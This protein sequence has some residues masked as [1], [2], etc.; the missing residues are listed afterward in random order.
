MGT[1]TK[2]GREFEFDDDTPADV[3]D[4]R[5]ANWMKEN[6]ANEL[7]PEAPKES[8]S[9]Y[10]PKLAMLAKMMGAALPGANLLLDSPAGKR[11]TGDVNAYRTIAQGALPLADEA[12]AGVRSM[13]PESWGGA[14]YDTALGQERQGV[15]DF[16]EEHGPMVSGGLQLLGTAATLPV[17]GALFQGAKA[18]PWAGRGVAALG[19]TAAAH[20]LLASPLAGAATGAATGFAS[21]EGGFENRLDNARDIG[22]MGAVLGPLGYG[23]VN[24]A[25]GVG[26][27]LG[28]DN[29][30]ANYLRK[31]LVNER[32]LA[33]DN[34]NFT[35]DAMTGLRKD[36]RE[37]G[38]LDTDPMMA[39]VLPRT[40]EAVFQK[41]GPDVNTLAKNILNRQF[42]QK[43]DPM[44]AK[45][46]GQHGRVGDAM[47][48]AWGPDMFKKSDAD[49][50]KARKAD[51]DA[52]YRP[53]YD[54]YIG[55]EPLNRA[56]ASIEELAPGVIGRAKA[57]AKSE[58]LSGA[59]GRLPMDRIAGGELYHNTE[60]LHDIKRMLD[61]HVGDISKGNF[62]FDDRPYVN[63]KKALNEAIG[64]Q[65]AAYKAANAR[66]GEHSD[67]EKA[68]LKGRE[69]VFVPGSVDKTGAMDAKA[70]KDYLAN[71][72][73]PPEQKDLFLT[74]AARAARERFLNT[75]AKKLS[76]NAADFINVGKNMD[77]IEALLGDKLTALSSGPT[78]NSWKL[79]QK[80]MATESQNY[81]NLIQTGLGNSRTAA[82]EGM[83]KDLEGG[84]F[85]PGTILSAFF[86]PSAPSTLRAAG[87][88]FD[89]IKGT[90]GKVNAV[91][92]ILGRQGKA[93]NKSALDDVERLLQGFDK[94]KSAYDYAGAFT[95]Y[96]ATYAGPR[97]RSQE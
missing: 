1:V 74:G 48:M 29:A 58:V 25:K 45:E 35:R 66:F 56:L 5:I 39:D 15:K 14:D 20:P 77:T 85:N 9:T 70:I 83:K 22:A 61:S 17:G 43:L 65:N 80:K 2:Y 63:A 97:K 87:M 75:D 95:P 24:A 10:N 89:K 64:G 59:P 84:D 28:K 44:L 94:R 21:G 53:A 88:L 40:A 6:A 33:P 19:R 67:L 96:A 78:I 62:K 7:E 4:K 49:I 46:A 34:P 51:A 52:M 60:F 13:L 50:L 47:D 73:I 57:F 23:A 12:T 76:H 16:E 31:Q 27:Y 90:E 68:L 55:G 72:N 54:Q 26:N 32:A 71:P 37:R 69:E 8:K 30:V 36:M 81:K 86:Q 41:Q 93:G 38:M 91:A 79:F 42:N 3:R 11:I 92:N 18:L 82:R